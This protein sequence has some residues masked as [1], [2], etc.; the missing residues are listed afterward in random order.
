MLTNAV[1]IPACRDVFSLEDI[2]GDPSTRS[3]VCCSCHS[4]GRGRCIVKCIFHH[5]DSDLEFLPPYDYNSKK[6]V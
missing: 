3:G 1:G 2:C 4:H 6:D 5:S